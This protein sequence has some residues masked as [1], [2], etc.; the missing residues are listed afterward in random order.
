MKK[1]ISYKGVVLEAFIYSLLSVPLGIMFGSHI[2]DDIQSRIFIGFIVWVIFFG[3]YLNMVRLGRIKDYLEDEG[4][5]D[6]E[7]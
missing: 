7:G 3:I 4:K 1:K 2:R 5:Q 6:E